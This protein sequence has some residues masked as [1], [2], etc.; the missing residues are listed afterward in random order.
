MTRPGGKHRVDSSDA[1]SKHCPTAGPPETNRTCKNPTDEDEARWKNR[2]QPM[3][4]KLTGGRQLTRLESD[5]AEGCIDQVA[6]RKS[7]RVVCLD[8]GFVGNDQLKTNAAQTFK[9]KGVTSFR[10]V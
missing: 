6:A 10:T 7:E 4:M 5:L 2:P 9:A 3:K 1:L 8:A